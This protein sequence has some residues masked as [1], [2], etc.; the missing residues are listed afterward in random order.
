M[1]RPAEAV[2]G[3]RCMAVVGLAASG[4]ATVEHLAGRDLRLMVFDE[5][6]EAGQLREWRARYPGVNFYAGGLDADL[7]CGADEI[8]VT[9]GIA[10]DRPELQ[11]ASQAGSLL[12]GEVELFSREVTQPVVAVTG[13][14]GK[15]TV[16]SLVGAMAAAAGLRVSV[17]GNLGQPALSL[18]ADDAELYVLELSSFQLERTFSLRA[19]VAAI[20]NISPDHFDRHSNMPEYHMLKH[21][22]Y[23]GAHHIIYNRDDSLTVPRLPTAASGVSFG[24]LPPN[25]HDWGLAR[26]NREQWIVHG[27]ERFMPAAEVSM[28]G[29]IGVLNALAALAIGGAVS[30]PIDTMHGVLA[31]FKGL[32]HR[33]QVVAVIDGVTYINDSKATNPGAVASLLNGLYQ[34]TGQRVL[35]ICGGRGKGLG[36]QRLQRPLA[37]T[38]RM[39]LTLGEEADAFARLAGDA[40]VR[41]CQSMSEAVTSAA[42]YARQ[43]DIVLLSPGCSSFDMFSDYRA[44]GDAFGQAV[45]ALVDSA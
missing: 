45:Q 32:P 26:I 37:R 31:E 36:Y 17:G 28:P 42:G 19:E 13:T 39:M 41:A 25:E 2:S 12:I 10:L 40:P 23:Q 30:V 15:S 16:V 24:L 8:V 22:I 9:P 38:L 18:L 43:G 20:L 14:N 11:A 3:Q 34:G 27:G 33:A 44:R 4:R 6:L 35:L 1:N 7:L 21:R 5:G 29:R